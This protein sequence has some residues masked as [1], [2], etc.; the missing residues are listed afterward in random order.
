MFKVKNTNLIKDSNEVIKNATKKTAIPTIINQEMVIEG[1]LIS[2]NIIEIFGKV[3]GNIKSDVLSIREGATV[4]GTIHA[5]YVKIAGNFKGN[6]KSS[7]IHITSN[8][9]VKG[10]MVYG[11][12]S[13]E[14][15]GKFEGKVSQDIELLQIKDCTA[16]GAQNS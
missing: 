1:D 13:V 12:L 16:E 5:T 15:K 4:D 6:I 3:K 11:I 10:E 9:E 8:G 14:E 7:V 2:S